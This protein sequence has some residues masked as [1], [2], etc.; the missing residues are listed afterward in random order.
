[1]GSLFVKSKDI[2]VDGFLGKDINVPFYLQFVPGYVVDVVTS[3]KSLKYGNNIRNINSILALPHITDELFARRATVSE[4]NRYYP[5][6]RG[7]VDV[8]T[9][10]DPVLLCTIGK[11]KYYLG[12]LNTD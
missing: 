9:K 10:G 5:L 7:M 12:P 1:M 3:N 11:I 2:K 8:P 6:L 4:E